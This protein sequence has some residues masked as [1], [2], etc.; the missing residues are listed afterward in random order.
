MRSDTSPLFKTGENTSSEYILEMQ[1]I[2]KEFPGVRALEKVNFSLRP[3]AIHA[4]VGEN[5]AGKSTMVKILAGVYPH[6]SFEGRILI[7]GGA[8][9]FQS[10]KDSEKAGVAIIYQEL[11]TVKELS[12]CENFFIGQEVAH[13]GIIDWNAQNAIVKTSLKNVSMESI[14]PDRKMKELGVGH[15]QL[16]E[17]A[18]ALH[19][20]ARILILDEPTSSLSEAEVEP[21]LRDLTRSPSAR[22]ELHLHFASSGRGFPDCRHGD[23]APRRKSHRN[24]ASRGDRQKRNDPHDGRPRAHADVP[25]AGASGG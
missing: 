15:Q 8:Q 2:T 23:G 1:E 12:I 14:N 4:L 18:K 13:H 3:G 25:A 5:G 17:I 16:V 9:A 24:K 19:K 7:D 21:A 6:G 10:I 11:A 22:V 20:H